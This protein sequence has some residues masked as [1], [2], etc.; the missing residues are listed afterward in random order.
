MRMA[1]EE[2]GVTCSHC[3]RLLRITGVWKNYVCP[4][5]GK[6]VFGKG[7][8]VCVRCGSHW[9]VIRKYGLY[10]CRRCFREIARSLGFRKYI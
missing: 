1:E 4:H 3:G 5:C 6:K 2:R 9:A 10:Y 7:S 8:R